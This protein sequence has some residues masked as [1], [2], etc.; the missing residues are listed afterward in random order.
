[1][2][3]RCDRTV[4]RCDETRTGSTQ[5]D[6]DRQE[7]EQ[8]QADQPGPPRC[9]EV[10]LLAAGEPPEQ[11][12]TATTAADQRERH[13]PPGSAV[14]SSR[15]LSPAGNLARR[16]GSMPRRYC[17]MRL[18][19]FRQ[20]SRKK[21]SD[22]IATA[23]PRTPGSARGSAARAST[24]ASSCQ[25]SRPV[26]EK[27][28][29]P[30]PRAD[31]D[32]DLQRVRASPSGRPPRSARGRSPARRGWTRRGPAGCPAGP[33]PRHADKARPGACRG[34]S[35]STGRRRVAGRLGLRSTAEVSDFGSPPPGGVSRT[36]AS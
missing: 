11:D 24:Q 25:T 16:R 33:R 28:S 1:M 14:S 10:R 30:S 9:R 34:R 4:S 21:T 31:G 27:A 36:L 20:R 19:T 17:Q 6:G 15:V 8:P 23:P 2:I 29:L 32:L 7:H 35:I 12:E 3:G 5:H 22:L 26:A 18:M 13:P